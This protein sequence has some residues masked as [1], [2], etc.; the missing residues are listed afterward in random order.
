VVTPH[1]PNDESTHF[2]KDGGTV[3]V[4]ASEKG[5][6]FRIIR[7]STPLHD[8]ERLYESRT[9]CRHHSIHVLVS[10]LPTIL[11]HFSV[12]VRRQE[13]YHSIEMH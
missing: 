8:M 10:Y 1:C 2:L 13:L 5:L 4:G 6:G 11:F 12:S 3:R 9:F 7:V